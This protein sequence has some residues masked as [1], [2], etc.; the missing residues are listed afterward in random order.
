M[1][2][3]TALRVATDDDLVYELEI[4]GFPEELTKPLRE[5]L[6]QPVADEVR[7][8]AWCHAEQME[9]RQ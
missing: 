9:D 3:Y 7:L 6:S 8:I 1:S 2:K 4:R 5:F